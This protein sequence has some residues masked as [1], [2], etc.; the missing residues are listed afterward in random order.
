MQAMADQGPVTLI[1][2]DGTGFLSDWDGPTVRFS[3]T[4]HSNPFARFA[5]ISAWYIKVLLYLS[6][7]LKSADKL[8]LSTLISSPLLLLLYFKRCS[9]VDVFVN[10][11]FFRI[12]AW[13]RIGLTAINRKDVRK[14]YLS[15]FVQD[16]WNFRGPS[17]I[18]YPSLRQS[19]VDRA[20][21]D[22]QAPSLDPAKVRFFLVCSQIPAKGY[23]LFIEIAKAFERN[24]AQHV[25]TLYMSG[26]HEKFSKEYPSETL[27][28]NITVCF[29]ETGPEI[30]FGHD[31]FLGLTNPAEWIETFGQTFAEAMVAGNIT[32][33]PPVGAQIEYLHDGDNGFVFGEYTAESLLRQIEYLLAM[34]D[35]A[36]LKARARS[37]MLAFLQAQQP[38]HP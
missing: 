36:L 33:A 16:T 5:S 8:I 9:S 6:R 19:I 22:T 10:E 13:R 3:Y 34:P 28:K 18:I 24:N 15:K 32:I 2:N 25:F 23:R 7:A 17:T 27:P 38:Y 26:S 14:I 37:S 4:K 31:I 29:N 30:F 12:P 21:Q 35:L 11:V 20:L 1:T